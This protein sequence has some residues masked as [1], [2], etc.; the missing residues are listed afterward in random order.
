MMMERMFQIPSHFLQ[1]SKKPLS[2][3]R[4]QLHHYVIE[5]YRGI[6]YDN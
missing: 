5:V 6:V 1:C 2:S 4:L 3:S